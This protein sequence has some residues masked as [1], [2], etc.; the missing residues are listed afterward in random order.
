LTV[1]YPAAALLAESSQPRGTALGGPKNA[2]D[3]APSGLPDVLTKLRSGSQLGMFS[4][5]QPWGAKMSAA[6]AV[7]AP[8]RIVPLS[9]SD[10]PID[11]KGSWR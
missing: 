8:P 6:G 11:P 7:F 3:K 1:E 4:R 2:S 10:H 5:R 9:E